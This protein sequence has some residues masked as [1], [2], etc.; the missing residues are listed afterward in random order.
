MTKKLNDIISKS[1]VFQYGIVSPAD[2]NFSEEV[3]KMCEVNTCRK[4]A[5]TWACPPGIGTID[6]C[7]KR[8]QAFDKMLVFTAKYNLE[9]SFDYEGMMSGMNNFK[10]VSRNLEMAIKP[11]LNNYLILSSEGCDICEQCTY[12]D[13]PCRFPDK[14][15]GSIEGYGIFVSELAKIAGI[16]YI[17]GKDTVTYFGALLFDDFIQGVE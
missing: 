1:G 4:Y 12:P 11:Y 16:N 3:R 13:Y 14:I 15:Y 9:D 17:N 5:T 8:C 2:V 6:E 7:R 10:Q